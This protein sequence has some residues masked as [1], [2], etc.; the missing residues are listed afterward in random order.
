[1][2]FFLLLGKNKPYVFIGPVLFDY[3]HDDL[4]CVVFFII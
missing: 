3:L 4:S 1:M 2:H